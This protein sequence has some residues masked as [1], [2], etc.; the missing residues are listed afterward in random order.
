MNG[1]SELGA[2]G[3]YDRQ[4]TVIAAAA[5]AASG[6]AST[7][8]PQGF[9]SLSSTG[10]KILGAGAGAVAG[11][12]TQH[13]VS[14]LFGRETHW[15]WR[16]IATS[17]LSAMVSAGVSG[18]AEDTLGASKF[19]SN[20]AGSASS[21]GTQMLLGGKKTVAE[22]AVD[23]FGSALANSYL[24]PLLQRPGN[25][26]SMDDGS[27]SALSGGAGSEAGANGGAGGAPGSP[28]VPAA[29]APPTKGNEVL[30]EIV[31]TGTRRPGYVPEIV[32][33]YRGREVEGNLSDP[34]RSLIFIPNSGLKMQPLKSVDIVG[35]KSL[36]F[37]NGRVDVMDG[38]FT[39]YEGLLPTDM[40]LDVGSFDAID[41]RTQY[42]DENKYVLRGEFADAEKSYIAEFQREVGEAILRR[43]PETIA[44]IRA[45]EGPAYLAGSVGART[46]LN[47]M[48]GYLI[49]DFQGLPDTPEQQIASFAF[50]SAVLALGGLAGAGAF[51][52]LGRQGFSWAYSSAASSVAADGTMQL[53]QRLGYE[54]SGGTVGRQEV[55]FL[56]LGLAA[57]LG[58]AGVWLG[59][60]VS[61]GTMQ[62]R[63]ASINP[64][65]AF[66]V[67]RLNPNQVRLSQKSV[68]YNKVDRQTGESYT[69]DDLV[70]SMRT[71]GWK[72]DPIDVVRMPDGRLTSMDNTRITAAREAGIDVRATV[73]NFDEP[74]TPQM[75]TARGWENHSTWGEAMLARIKIQGTKFSTANPYG[76]MQS[77]RVTGRK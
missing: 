63:P 11:Y 73:R 71:N 43:D 46:R 72:G 2:K 57:P 24:V 26:N 22:I 60:R 34:T 74:L 70:N 66:P 35:G 67:T 3:A 77:P 49:P 4:A 19:W 48:F 12:T 18:Y 33:V 58:V 54:M 37:L 5:G 16:D 13:V 29:G 15:N 51:G 38:E 31:V 76:T 23:V 50:N 65:N 8:V 1:P 21:V 27:G 45:S 30:E 40:A 56:E 14:N 53:T 25:Q 68:S 7:Y 32:P 42:I 61:L 41:N 47:A 28:S 52:Y 69:Y 17:A 10:A 39:F 9:G 64:L 36:Y 55:S 44:A 20:V 75:Q 62:T 6:A 59:N